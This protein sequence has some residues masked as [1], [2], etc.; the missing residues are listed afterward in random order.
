MKTKL[1]STLLGCLLSL[2][3]PAI[4]WAAGPGGG[5]QAGAQCNFLNL[6]KEKKATLEATLLFMREEE[7]MARDLYLRFKNEYAPYGVLIFGNIAA[8]EQKHM[9]AVKRLLDK[10]D[11]T[12]PV[13]DNAIGEFA[14]AELAAL[15][16]SLLTQGLRGVKEAF[17][18]GVQV[19]ETDI[20]DLTKAIAE[21]DERCIDKVYL[22][23]LEG[24]VRHLSAFKRKLQ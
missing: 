22:N 3:A 9:D 12:D 10:Y 6:P 16:E 4:T 19:E 24:S 21:S 13:G 15:Y 2:S 1:I 11:L 17:K 7:K 14:N 8:S 5:Q 18:V 20:R 23:L